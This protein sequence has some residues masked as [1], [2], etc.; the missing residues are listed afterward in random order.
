MEEKNI[1]VFDTN[2]WTTPVGGRTARVELEKQASILYKKYILLDQEAR[3][4]GYSLV[5]L[6]LKKTDWQTISNRYAELKQWVIDQR[7]K[8]VTF[9]QVKT[10]YQEHQE[11]YY[12]Q[13]MVSGYLATWQ[14]GMVVSQENIEISEETVRIMTEIYPELEVLLKDIVVGQQVAWQQDGK[15]YTFTCENLEE[16]GVVPLTEITNAV[17]VQYAESMV[18]QWLESNSKS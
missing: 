18:D 12:R 10:Y 9:E 13:D 7:L 4:N 11:K 1:K 5:A 17:A 6:D 16:K 14:E 3:K 2:F 8:T 15:Y